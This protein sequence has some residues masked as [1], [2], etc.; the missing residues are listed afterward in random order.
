MNIK[1]KNIKKVFIAGAYGMVGSALRRAYM[2]SKDYYYNRDRLLIPKRSDL[3]L[4]NFEEV[5]I[6]FSKNKPEYVIIAAAKVGGIYANYTYPYEFILNNLKIQT[7]LIEIS[8]K[9]KH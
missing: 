2:K 6:W 9:H 8:F 4:T 3:D 5:E 1:L 7:N